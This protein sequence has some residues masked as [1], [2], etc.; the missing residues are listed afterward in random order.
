MKKYFATD[1]GVQV[2]TAI[3][4]QD[5]FTIQE[6]KSNATKAYLDLRKLPVPP[7]AVQFH[8]YF[9]AMLKLIPFI[10]NIPA[11]DVLENE[12]DAVSNF[13][14]DQA[15]AYLVLTQKI[16]QEM[17]RLQIKYGG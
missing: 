7:D 13:W 9:M 2:E 6:L 14:Y 17:S 3:I 16:N 1:L 5:A 12:Y 8:K 15:Q 4:N 10:L 11:P